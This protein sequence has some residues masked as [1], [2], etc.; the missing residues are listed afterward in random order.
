MDGYSLIEGIG[1]VVWFSVD[2]KKS[3]SAGLGVRFLSL[4]GASAELVRNIVA[5]YRRVG[6]TSLDLDGESD[7]PRSRSHP[8]KTTL[9][10]EERTA[11]DAI[12]SR[13]YTVT[14]KDGSTQ[15]VEADGHVT[16]RGELKFV[17][18]DE[19]RTVTI[20]AKEEWTGF[21]LV[22]PS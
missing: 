15:E 2:Q 21:S 6:R 10:L 20:F 12:G 17:V 7:F 8:Q 19:L 5:E 14:L 16:R 22:G 13:I 3:R 9:P 11:I 1:E 18:G 4:V